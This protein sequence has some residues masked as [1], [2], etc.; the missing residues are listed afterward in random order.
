MA[1]KTS[2]EASNWMVP[3]GVEAMI[4][5]QRPAFTTRS[6]RGS[7]RVSPRPIV[8]GLCSSIGG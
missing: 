8:S 6:T 2:T 7:T 1:E 3:F 4:E 5:M